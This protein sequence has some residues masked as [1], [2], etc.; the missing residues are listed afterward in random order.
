MGAVGHVGERA[1]SITRKAGGGNSRSQVN[2]RGANFLLLAFRA[3]SRNLSLLRVLE[4]IDTE[5]VPVGIRRSNLLN[6]LCSRPI[7]KLFFTGN[8]ILHVLMVFVVDELLAAKR[9]RKPSTNSLTMFAVRR[10]KSFVIPR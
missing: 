1:V 10:A 5:I 6:L 8:G 3:R 9:S 7:L 2:K 4:D